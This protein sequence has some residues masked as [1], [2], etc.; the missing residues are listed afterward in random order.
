MK[1]LLAGLFV[2]T[3]VMSCAIVHAQSDNDKLWGTTDKLRGNNDT[4]MSGHPTNN[5]NFYNPQV[6][7]DSYM[8]GH[9]SNNPNYYGNSSNQKDSTPYGNDI[10]DS[11]PYY[12]R[13]GN[14]R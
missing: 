10:R 3:F 6:Q 5:P 2:A 4:Y 8:S 11:N 7:H 12:D 9:P 14:L 13:D 1:K